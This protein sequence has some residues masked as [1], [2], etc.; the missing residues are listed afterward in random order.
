MQNLGLII[1]IS[2]FWLIISGCH[3][4]KSANAQTQ[5]NV[6]GSVENTDSLMS[7]EPNVID[8][9][10]IDTDD[11]RIVP[12]EFKL[13]NNSDTIMDISSIDV[14][15]NC[16]KILGYTKSISINQTG[17]ISGKIDLRNQSGHLRKSIYV[18]YNNDS[19]KLLKIIGD[20]D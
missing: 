17:K 15:C 7:F 18:N 1:I 9:G 20:I 12:F 6:N 14:S 10:R 8:L 4:E 19:M 2:T 3:Y 11:N 13:T 16:V 5:L